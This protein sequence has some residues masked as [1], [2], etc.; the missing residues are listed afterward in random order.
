MR[1]L[2]TQKIAIAGYEWLASAV[3]PQ[4]VDLSGALLTGIRPFAFGAL[5]ILSFVP[6][7]FVPYFAYGYIDYSQIPMFALSIGVLFCHIY[8]RPRADI[9]VVLFLIFCIA[10]FQAFGTIHSPA[11]HKSFVTPSI[12]FSSK[13]I[14]P[15]VMIL[16]RSYPLSI[17]TRMMPRIVN[18]ILLF[19][20]IECITR[21]IFSPDLRI[22]GLTMYSDEAA[23]SFLY[24][25]KSSLFFYDSNFVGVEIICL[26]SIMFAF[27]GAID[28]KKILLG[29]LLLFTT[30]SRASI[31]SGICLFVVY[32]LWR[33]RVWTF[34]GL[35]LAQAL[36]IAKL[37]IDYST[38][39]SEVTKS[40]DGSFSSKFLLLSIMVNIYQEADRAQK[41]FG[42]GAGNFINLSGSLSSH[43]ILATFVTELGIAGSI[44]F[45]VYI[46]TH[47]RKC[48]T[49]NCLLILPVVINGFS[50]ISLAAMPFFFATLGLLGALRGTERDGTKA[51]TF[52]ET[53]SKNRTLKG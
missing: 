47:S 38:Q 10:I 36:I 23:T 28:G 42:I 46:W 5:L 27:R 7:S 44:L 48:P 43:N 26:L 35:L 32:K 37:F 19:L 31:V 30:F 39:G 45:I 34:F 6:I 16:A 24:I 13:L 2:S 12:F 53:I 50:L 22:A 25:Y 3:K 8:I 18:W 40:I 49:S 9:S 33:W 52:N 4:P 41:L 29:Y 14:A 20:V 11:Y 15:A 17:L 1:V 21:L 51:L